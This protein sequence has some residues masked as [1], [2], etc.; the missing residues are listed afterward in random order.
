M[1]GKSYESPKLDVLNA[2][3]WMEKL[4]IELN[5]SL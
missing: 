3:N 1:D 5:W 2:L 4:I